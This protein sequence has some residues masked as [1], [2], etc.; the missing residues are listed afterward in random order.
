MKRIA[1]HF[2]APNNLPVAVLA[3]AAL[4][5][6]AVAPCV[7]A[8]RRPQA[9]GT[10]RV[11]ISE[12]LQSLDPRLWPSDSA[13]AAVAERVESL[14]Y[15]RLVQLDDRG[16]PRA[17]LATSWQHDAQSK[18]WQFHLR[19]DVKFT[20]GTPLSPTI[21]ALAL[22]QL[23]GASFDVSATSDS[24]IILAE[25]SVPMLP[26]QLATGRYFIF[27]SADDNAL[28][29]TGPFEVESSLSL[30]ATAKLFL[31]ANLSNWAGRPFLD[32]IE[33][34]MGID[35]QQ[36]AN[37]ISFGQ[38]D[39]VELPASQVRRAAQRGVLI[40]SS[41]PVEL[42]ALVFDASRTAVQDP[43]LRQA[44]SLGIDRASIADVILQRQAVVAGSL[45]PNW[46]SGYAHLF[47]AGADLPR[48]RDLLAASSQAHSRSMPLV[49]LCDSSDAEARAVADRVTV[50]L[51]ELGILVQVAGKSA[52]GKQKPVA[53]DFTLVRERIA[54]PDAA[55]ALSQL[56]QTLGESPAGMDTLEQIYAAERSP[57]D[58]FQMIP[59]VH[60]SESFGLSPQVRDWTPPHWGGW[61]LE[62]VW[63]GAPNANGGRPQ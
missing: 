63:L 39:V 35:L 42:F 33:L 27:R 11:Q 60:V 16:N 62:D 56:F 48:A 12:R 49:L 26:I 7:T 53:A 58:A 17:A 14:L 2:R 15:D 50:N 44:I 1:C 10:L 45:L 25:H 57:V 23:L 21:A 37:A 13:H 24:V 4:A 30:G 51:R 59:L 55:I 52:D 43:R 36:Q 8:S 28:S 46:I 41:D 31:R 20:D 61:R 34:T 6:F 9:G 19:D 5:S 54:S 47:S 38:A 18:T 3:F 29:G 22:Q 32:K 40:A